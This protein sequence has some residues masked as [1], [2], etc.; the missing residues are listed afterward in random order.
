MMNQFKLKYIP[1]GMG[2]DHSGWW[3]CETKLYWGV[4]TDVPVKYIK[5]ADYK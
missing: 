5:R 1:G 3:L 2:L 4:Y